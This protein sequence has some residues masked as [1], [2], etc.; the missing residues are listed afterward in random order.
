MDY[1][2]EKFK[3][4]E[5]PK[6]SDIRGNLSVCE[7]KKHIPFEA[8]RIFFIYQVPLVEIRGQHAHKEC[9][10]FLMCVRGSIKALADDGFHRKEFILNS[11][12]F[13]L[14]LPPMV[15][16]AQYNYS[17][18]AFLIVFASEFYDASDYIREYSEFE[19]MIGV[20]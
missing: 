8:K 13:G 2:V 17:P 16:G 12:N 9:H 11:P 1:D 6:I 19:S 4:I 18:D 20:K 14:Y 5:L 3:I 7:F 15:W 10:Q